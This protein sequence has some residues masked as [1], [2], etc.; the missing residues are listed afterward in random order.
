LVSVEA[1]NRSFSERLRLNRAILTNKY[2]FLPVDDKG[3]ENYVPVGRGV[4]SSDF[5]GRWVSFSVCKNVEGHNHMWCTSSSCP[6]CFNRGWS[7]REA[8][9]ITGRVDEAGKRGVGRVEHIVVSPSPIDHDLSESVL[10]EKCRKVLLGRG[11]IGGCMIFHGFREDKVRGVLAWSPHYHVLGYIEGGYGCR[12]CDR[13]NNCLKGCGGFDDRNYNEGFLKDG[14][15]VKVLAERE[16]AYGSAWY[17]LN[18][19]TVRLGVKRFHSVTWFGACSY[20][21]FK[22]EK[23]KSENVCPACREEMVRCAYVGKRHIVKDIG[24]VD[25]V[26]LFIDDEFGE[27]S[28]AN[29]VEVV[30][31]RGG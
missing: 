8:H 1:V 24:S 26:S 19:A 5:C 2:W 6:I 10:R 27:G 7:V 4:K 20:R 15:L 30:G 14:Y 12:G 18:H 3:H 17:Q 21:K 16:T 23:V 31:G 13:K 22:A 28:E 11:V 29:Y 25:Y 9:S